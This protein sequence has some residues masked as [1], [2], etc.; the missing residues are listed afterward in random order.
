MSQELRSAQT[1]VTSNEVHAHLYD[2]GARHVCT[3]GRTVQITNAKLH[4][5]VDE[6][7][8]LDSGEYDQCHLTDA[9]THDGADC[10]VSYAR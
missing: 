3:H 5:L 6:R 4:A 1:C 7:I 9:R 8:V 2:V 10:I